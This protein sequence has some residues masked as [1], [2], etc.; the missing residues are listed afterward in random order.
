MTEKNDCATN[1][2]ILVQIMSAFEKIIIYRKTTRHFAFPT[3]IR[4]LH[5]VMSDKR[6]RTIPSNKSLCTAKD[7]GSKWKCKKWFFF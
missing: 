2:K 1:S 7:D 4:I 3:M 6:I 5:C